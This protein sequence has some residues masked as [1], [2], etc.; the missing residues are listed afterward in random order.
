MTLIVATLHQSGVQFLEPPL[1]AR[2]D[3]ILNNTSL[4][5]LAYQPLSNLKK[6][7]SFLSKVERSE[8]KQFGP[9]PEATHKCAD[10]DKTFSSNARLQTHRASFH[11]TRDPWRAL[12]TDEVCPLCKQIFADKRGAQLHVQRVCKFKFPRALDPP[13]PNVPRGSVLAQ[14]IN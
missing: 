13:D 7:L 9:L 14:L 5:R 12:V 1:N 3:V 6:V 2:R 4:A 11:K 10:C 8:S